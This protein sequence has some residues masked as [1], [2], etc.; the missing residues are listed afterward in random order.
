MRENVW[1]DNFTWTPEEIQQFTAAETRDVRTELRGEYEPLLIIEKKKPKMGEVDWIEGKTVTKTTS[2]LKDEGSEHEDLDE[3]RRKN[4]AAR[5]ESLEQMEF[6]WMKPI[7][8]DHY[9]K[10]APNKT[11][12]DKPGLRKERRVGNEKRIEE[13]GGESGIAGRWLRDHGKAYGA[14]GMALPRLSDRNL[15]SHSRYARSPAQRFE[16]EG[17][18]A[19]DSLPKTEDVY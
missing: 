13:Y 17:G 18:E 2:A 7:K 5:K 4:M 14:A 9:R 15:Q 16:R 8:K 1:L 3:I 12:F 19:V 6:A 10:R 11:A